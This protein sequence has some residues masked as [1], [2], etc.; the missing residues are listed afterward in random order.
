MI[1]MK[2]LPIKR[3][4]YI[5]CGSILVLLIAFFFFNN[6]MRKADEKLYSLQHQITLSSNQIL[7]IRRY[8]K[9]F[10]ARKDPIY[11]EKLQ[12]E[13]NELKQ[14][15]QQLDK[16]LSERGIESDF[17]SLAIQDSIDS[18]IKQFD[19]IIDDFYAIYGRSNHD[20]YIEE[21]NLASL[22]L[23]KILYLV[24]DN[25]LSSLMF[26]NNN[27]VFGL[28]EK[29]VPEELDD[30]VFNINLLKSRVY[31]YKENTE[32][33]NAYQEFE[34]HF[35]IL[36]N[37]YAQFGYD[38]NS[39]ELGAL[40]T[41]INGIEAQLNAL[42]AIMPAKMEQLHF[43]HDVYYYLMILCLC[44]SMLSVFLF[45]TRSI[46]T[47]EHELINSQ[48][49]EKQANKAK[50]S[51]LANM[52]HEIRTPLNGIIGMTDILK[53]S[54]LTPM[55][56][57]YLSTINTSSQTL[58]MLIND[59]LDLSKIE[60]GNID[61]HIQTCAIKEVMYDTAALIASK[62]EMKGV[63]I[64]VQISTDVPI[65]VLAD[66]QKLRQVMM[67][68]ASNAIKFTES[69]SVTLSLIR[70]PNSSTRDLE[71][72]FSVIDTGIGINKDKQVQ[73]FDEFSQESSSTASIYGGTGLG[74]AISSKLIRMMGGEIGVESEKGKGSAFSF[75]IEL[76]LERRA[77][78][79]D[80]KRPIIYC[81][82]SPS[83][84]LMADLIGMKYQIFQAESI[85]DIV[86]YINERAVLI[87]S[88]EYS[89]EQIS[90]IQQ[91][92][93][94][95]PML[96]TRKNSVAKIDY[97]HL[98][99]GY[100]TLPLLGNRVDKLIQSAKIYD[101]KHIPDITINNKPRL[102]VRSKP[103]EVRDNVTDIGCVIK[104]EKRV[105]DVLVVEDNK[106]NQLV[107]TS[108][109]KK[110]KCNY[111][112]ANNGAEAVEI[113][114]QHHESISLILMD[115]M[116]PVLDG[117][118]ATQQIRAFEQSRAIAAKQIIAITASIIDDDI[119]Q[120]FDAGMDDFLPK[121]FSKEAFMKKI[122]KQYA[123]G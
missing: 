7:M 95:L 36:V 46:S 12:Q 47:L 17:D 1:V 77:Q 3:L 117:F 81:S 51:F 32:L 121:P 98:I 112:I 75:S 74:L 50:S 123:M 91:I 58:L 94:R 63:E 97:G 48:E 70:L 38:Y 65:Y 29:L 27:F 120:C 109:L 34:R 20:G 45:T 76:G 71:L 85:D 8:E 43:S 31:A 6:L 42:Y 4:L 19:I 18:Y 68:L 72:C 106:I 114:K 115:C 35:Y 49:K 54:K 28:N 60:S 41:T 56:E 111:K 66:D 10:L 30:I 101:Q 59:I 110:L 40:R 80:N 25:E 62:A 116:M 14:Q 37:A 86:L 24:H 88:D 23:Q 119:K 96:I 122:K 5:A 64:E 13:S 22:N 118:Q 103:R 44:V 104:Q 105:G 99:A 100:I 90:A 16:E 113:Y 87:I 52:S 83:D 57:D 15:I 61:L 11:I 84:L 26:N 69:G 33:K 67:N 89:I 39:G 82:Q 108:H 73:I 21:L 102:D 55:Q 78:Q 2:D 9:D 79:V 92:H 107:I 53:D 93:P